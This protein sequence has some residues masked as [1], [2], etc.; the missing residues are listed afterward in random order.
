V[1]RHRREAAIAATL[2]A[3]Y[4]VLAFVA[5][6]FFTRENF[7]DLFLGNFPVLLVAIGTTLVMLAGEIDISVGSM[8][9][10]CGVVAGASAVAG[11]P[12]PVV[13]VVTC[14]AGALLGALNGALVAYAGLPSIV[15]TLATMIALR[16]GLRWTT[17]GAWVQNLPASFQWLGLSQSRF[18][19]SAALVGVLVQIV[20]SWSARRVAA[21]RSVYATG[22]DLHA[23]RLA[24]I[25]TRLVKFAVIAAGGAFT[26]AA[27]L[28]NAVRFSQV[29]SNAGIGLEMK[30]IAAVVVGGTAVRGGRGSLTGTLLG[31]A[32]LASVG[33]ALVFLGVTS[34][35]ERAIYGVIV[36][37]AVTADAW[38]ARRTRAVV[39][40][41][42]VPA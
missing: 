26:G 6:G 5:P 41:T 12:M 16:D 4:A 10:I 19:A 38:N 23:A 7:S 15:V 34:A 31:V 25:D 22:S 9:A 14:A 37:A 32:L 18:L 28:L 13:A 35:W 40:R 30:V 17:Q 2:A 36:L 27:A 33:P 1:T 3:L 8:F 42:G 20:L 29:P 39:S 21:F 11:M 24:G